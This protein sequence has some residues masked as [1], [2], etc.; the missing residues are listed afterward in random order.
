MSYRTKE[1][2]NKGVNEKRWDVNVAV[3]KHTVCFNLVCCMVL[4][5]C[6]TYPRIR[7]GVIE[8][9]LRVLTIMKTLELSNVSWFGVSKKLRAFA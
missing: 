5:T 2:A 6:V 1:L 4:I 9:L 8:E 7:L 3:E